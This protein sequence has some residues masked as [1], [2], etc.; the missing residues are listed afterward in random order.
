MTYDTGDCL[1]FS[2]RIY[3]LFAVQSKGGRD[4]EISRRWC[5]LINLTFPRV[6]ELHLIYIG[7]SS[8]YL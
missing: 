3:I 8:F 6:K 7:G 5:R 1:T 2:I 4:Y